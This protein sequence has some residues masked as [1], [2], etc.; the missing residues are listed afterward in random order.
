MKKATIFLLLTI[1]VTICCSTV[2][3]LSFQNNPFEQQRNIN[4]ELTEFNNKWQRPESHEGDNG[5]CNVLRLLN[6]DY[7]GLESVK[8]SS[9]QKNWKEAEKQLLIYFKDTRG[10]K[11][12]PQT[13]LSKQD[14]ECADKALQ[15]MF[16]GNKTY[17]PTF[18][19]VN[20]DWHNKAVLNGETIYDAEWLFQYHRL[21][22]WSSLAQAYDVTKD[23]RYFKEW[24]YELIDYMANNLPI[25]KKTPWYIRRGMETY[26]R[27][28]RHISVLPSFIRSE[29]FDSKTLLYFLSSFHQQAEHIRTVYAHEGNHLV[30][31]LHAV[32]KN[33]IAFPE[34]K[35]SSEWIDEALERFPQLMFSELFEDGMNRELVFSY[36]GMYIGLFS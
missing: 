13:K 32:F 14:S 17:P 7:P 27:C 25:T 31:E 21:T 18:R 20:I 12:I 16:R 29:H 23:E 34:F 1:F 36:H 8:E 6:L 11:F 22:W 26:D 28:S 33:G 10:S 30:G 4:A 24:Q 35:K 2:N 3:L 5:I 9:K 15:H 19:G